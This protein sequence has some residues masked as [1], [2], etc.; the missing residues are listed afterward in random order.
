MLV[1]ARKIGQRI[2][3]GFDGGVEIQVI[4]IRGKR[5]RLGIL[6]PRHVPVHRAEAASN[7]RLAGATEATRAEIQTPASSE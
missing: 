4:E 3:V 6:A 2:V 5:V 1:L 7:S